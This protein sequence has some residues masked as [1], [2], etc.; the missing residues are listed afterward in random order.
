[1]ARILVIDDDSALLDVVSL[2]IGDAGHAVSTAADGDAGWRL[3]QKACP[4]LIVSDINMPS[5]D[6]FALLRKFRAAGHVE[7]VILLTSREFS[8][9]VST[10]S[11]T[12]GTLHLIFLYL[13]HGHLV[14]ECC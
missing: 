7:P 11:C 13:H 4:E 14:C 10:A 9:L 5:L 3:I 2:A 8:L 6:G 1:M 12:F